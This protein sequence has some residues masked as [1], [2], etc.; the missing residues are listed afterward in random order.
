MALGLGHLGRVGNALLRHSPTLVPLLILVGGILMRY[1]EPIFVQ[2]LNT[3]TFDTMQR[4]YPRHYEPDFPVRILDID[5]QSLAQ[6]GQWPWPRDLLARIVDKLQQ[7]GAAA[8]AFDIVFAEADRTSPEEILKSSS[9][10][11]SDPIIKARL[12]QL[13]SHDQLFADALRRSNAVLGF[14]NSDTTANLPLP[15]P[16]G[17]FAHAGPPQIDT[18]R[19]YP[20]AIRN[21]PILEDAAVGDGV[22]VVELPQDF[23]IRRVPVLFNIRDRLYPS[24][25]AEAIRVAQGARTSIV[26][27]SG[28]SGEQSFGTESGVA[29]IKVGRVVIPTDAKGQ[30]V[31]YD[32]GYQ[33]ARYISVSDFLD[34]KFDPALVRD[35]IIVVGTSAPGLKDLRATPLNPAGAGVEVHAQ[36]LEQMLTGVFLYD[37]DWEKGVDIVYILV[38]GL[39]L[40]LLMR[41]LG[42]VYSGP[43]ALIFVGA[44]VVATWLSFTQAGWMVAPVFPATVMALIFITGTSFSYIRSEIERRQVRNAFS[45][46][47][48]PEMVRRVA[49]DPAALNLGGEEREVTVM[50]TDI[51]GFTT[52]SE[53]L[54][55]PELTALLNGFLTPMTNIIQTDHK[56]TVD[57]YMGDAIM[58]FWNAPLDDADHAANACRA[59]LDMRIRLRELNEAW[60]KANTGYPT[61]NIGIGLNSGPVTVGNFGSEQRM[62]YSIIG[63]AANLASRLE[64]QTKAYGV[65]ILISAE[66]FK[67]APSF[68]TLE[69]DLIKVKGKREPARIYALIGTPEDTLS[70]ERTELQRL[71]AEF[72][73]LYRRGDFPA[74]R[75]A[76]KAAHQMAEAG[77]W[78]QSYYAA[79]R[80]RLDQLG[81][82]APEGWEGVF[83]ATSK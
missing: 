17:N 57:K 5:D 7:D 45:L 81:N 47:L 50:F 34:A 79:M 43:V 36:I 61:L 62:A 76:L 78:R 67:R 40:I 70:P 4:L 68:K 24:L 69:L 60:E 53:G 77:N 54:K 13:P 23:T 30:I 2:R 1:V 19:Y 26:K 11:A 22:F 16:M 75:T 15:K 66:V 27:W 14:P 72:L 58:A 82:I 65:D 71:Q 63:D 6:F 59:A 52:I 32:S 42:A 73:A 49:D 39:L 3:F 29:Q 9:A 18:L 44:P 31:L 51:R 83:E 46:Y 38:L 20:A 48:S 25:S 80:E 8:I 21:L 74:A 28:G 12:Q 37:V 56:G 41:K 33:A 55:P 64:G 35:K 10:L